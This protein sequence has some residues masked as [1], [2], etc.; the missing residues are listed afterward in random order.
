MDLGQGRAKQLARKRRDRQRIIKE[1]SVALEPGRNQAAKQRLIAQ[2]AP[3]QRIEAAYPYGAKP[4][5]KL[6]QLLRLRLSRRNHAI[7][8]EEDA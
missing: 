6:A 4:R 8:D 2:P 7:A 5:Q 1:Y 3:D